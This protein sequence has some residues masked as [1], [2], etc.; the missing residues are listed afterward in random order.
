MYQIETFK[1]IK[2]EKKIKKNIKYG[3]SGNTGKNYTNR[4]FGGAMSN[5]K[6]TKKQVKSHKLLPNNIRT[7]EISNIKSSDKILV[8]PLYPTTLGS[9]GPNNRSGYLNPN[10]TTKIPDPNNIN[11]YIYPAQELTDI[12]MDN[13]TSLLDKNYKIYIT[14]SNNNNDKNINDNIES[15]TSNRGYGNRWNDYDGSYNGGYNWG[16]GF[17]LNPWLSYNPYLFGPDPYNINSDPNTYNDKNKNIIINNYK[18]DITEDMK[19]SNTYNNEKNIIPD[20]INVIPDNKP[21]NK[22]WSEY[23]YY[24]IIFIIIIIFIKIIF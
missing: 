2:P 24:I 6:Y 12:N 18:K 15:N 1:K 22:F 20:N 7:S 10:S 3:T 19:K 14:N 5:R 17:G 16:G 8:P 13:G 21:D 4:S 9:V 23:I 11:K